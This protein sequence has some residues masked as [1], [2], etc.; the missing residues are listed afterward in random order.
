MLLSYFELQIPIRLRIS[1]VIVNYN[2]W[3]DVLNQV[4]RIIASPSF[5]NHQAEV[6]VVD[7]NSSQPAPTVRPL[8]NH[9]IWADL[10]TNGGFSAGVNEGVRRS[11][12]D[13]ILVLNPDA[14]L[15][16]NTIDQVVGMADDYDA[17]NRKNSEHKIGKI[18]RAH[19]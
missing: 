13:W 1:I 2:S 12:G 10:K 16:Q 8:T 18:G 5:L 6:V 15:Q 14:E 11:K 7:N 3:T 19:V 17:F 4:Q 9:L